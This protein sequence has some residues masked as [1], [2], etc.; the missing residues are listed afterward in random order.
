MSLE[1]RHSSDTNEWYTP[2]DV[3]EA[4][5]YA[6][7]SIDLDPAT[8]YK[9]NAI[10]KAEDCYTL[11]ENGLLQRWFGNVFLNPPGGL[12]DADD[13]PVFVGTKK[14]KSCLISGACGLPPGHSHIG[15][16]SSAK[17]WW[18]DAAARWQRGEIKQ[19]GFVAFS[20]ELLQTTQV[21][22]PQG[23]ALPL[24]GVFCIPSRRLAYFTEDASGSLVEGAS[25]T[26]A[27]MLVML[28]ERGNEKACVARFREAFAPIGRIGSGI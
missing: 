16:V 23:L 27:S 24:D 21:G 19:L 28:P 25:P 22:S 9:A 7:G 8:C 2:P 26:H 18:F 14:R 11:E 12:V 17:R 1:A 5:R 6:M 15:V 13:R 3:I 4:F 10:V 20:I